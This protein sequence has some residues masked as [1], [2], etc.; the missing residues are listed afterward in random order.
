[1]YNDPRSI[2]QKKI[3][4]LLKKEE[5]GIDTIFEKLFTI[6]QILVLE[7]LPDMEKENWRFLLEIYNIIGMKDFVKLIT[8]LKTKTVTFPSEEELKDSILT[9]MCYY[10]KDVE[11]KSWKEIT[12]LL[13]IPNLNTIKYGIRLRQLS[14][15]ISMKTKGVV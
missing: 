5:E 8:L 13:N 4:N 15:F 3:Q 6:Q 14:E 10:Y 12:K 9:V 2:F 11:K 7:R 1:M